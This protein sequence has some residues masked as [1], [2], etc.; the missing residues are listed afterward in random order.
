MS[1]F[2]SSA[3]DLYISLYLSCSLTFSTFIIWWH[4]PKLR[5]RLTNFTAKVYGNSR[6]Q[7]TLSHAYV[8]RTTSGKLREKRSVLSRRLKVD[9]ELDERTS[10]DRVFQT[11]AAAIGKA[12]SPTVDR[13]DV[14]TANVSDDHD[15]SHD[16]P[17]GNTPSPLFRLLPSLAPFVSA[18]LPAIIATEINAFNATVHS[19]QSEHSKLNA[20]ACNMCSVRLALQTGR[21]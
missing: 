21:G 18:F 5:G 20:C 19:R 9:R 13:F 2:I 4:Q 11:R 15:G 10:G 8:V 7:I 16:Y 1:H 6:S 12:R 17:S 14:G 3:V